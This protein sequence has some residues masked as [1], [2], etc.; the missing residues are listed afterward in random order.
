[1]LKYRGPPF[2]MKLL[3]KKEILVRSGV[4]FG[5]LVGADLAGSLAVGLLL[6]F[7]AGV[8]LFD[9][10]TFVEMALM[11]LAGGLY[12]WSQSEWM[13]GFRR[14]TGDKDAVYSRERHGEADRKGISFLLAGCYFL[15]LA[16]ALTF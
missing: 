4:Y 13:V 6:G 3:T 2:G 14:V 11:F 15:L 9:A 12:D 10:A 8:A 7:G 1:M 16:I 5:V